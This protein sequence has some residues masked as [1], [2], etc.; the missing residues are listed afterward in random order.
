MVTCP[1]K[2]NLIS[3]THTHTKKSKAFLNNGYI[4]AK[5]VEHQLNAVEEVPRGSAQWCSRLQK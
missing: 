4:P 2:Y 5:M 1:F 3:Y